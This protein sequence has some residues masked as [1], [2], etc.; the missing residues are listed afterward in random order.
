MG[1]ISENALHN[2]VSVCFSSCQGQV[3]RLNVGLPDFEIVLLFNSNRSDIERNDIKELITN[4]SLVS[5]TSHNISAGARR[6]Y[7][8]MRFA[9]ASMAAV[10]MSFLNRQSQADFVYLSRNASYYH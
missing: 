8:S 1:G 5:L 9:V 6:C 10:I 4:T 3:F 2:N 7:G